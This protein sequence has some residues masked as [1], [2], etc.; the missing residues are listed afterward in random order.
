MNAIHHP[1]ENIENDRDAVEIWLRETFLERKN[2]FFIV[3]IVSAI[4]RED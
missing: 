2:K 1:P 3:Q 4:G